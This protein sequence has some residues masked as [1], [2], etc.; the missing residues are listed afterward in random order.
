MRIDNNT[1]SQ[2][3]I[4][5]VAMNMLSE[6]AELS[7]DYLGNTVVQKLFEYC[8]ESVKEAMLE[9][10]AP[11]MAEIGI[12]KNG[13]WAA[14]KIIDVARTPTL[15]KMIV[16]SLRPYAMALFLD[17]FGNYVMQGCLRYQFP[18]N[19]FIFEV[20]L[21]RLWELAQGRFGA[22]A[23][24]ACL[25]SHHATKDQ[26]RMIAAAIALHS[27]QLATNANGALLL[28][29]FLDT[30]TF[31]RRR[32]VLAPRLV[33]HLVHLCTH[34]VAYLTVLKII[35]QRNEPEARDTILQALFFSPNDHVLE[36]ILS[37]H[38]SGTTLIF[39]VLTTP[40]FDEK[41]RPDVVQNVRNVLL[42]IKAQPQH[43][44]KRLM[45]EVGLSTRN[46]GPGARD[47][48][49]IRDDGGRPGSKHSGVNGHVSQPAL[50]N[51]QYYGGVPQQ[52]FDPNIGL[53]RTGSMDS[54]GFEQYQGGVNSLNSPVYAPSPTLTMPT[55]SPQHIQYQQAML[56]NAARNGSIYSP[57][58]VNMNGFQN[59]ASS[60][61]A[62]RNVGTSPTSAPGLAPQFLPQ[63]GFAQPGFSPIMTPQMYQYPIGMQYV[64]QQPQHVGVGRRGRR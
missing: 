10:I 35:N 62:F 39:K 50:D 15:M 4:E 44:Y 2:A 13:T 18:L 25:E 23:M 21:S 7:S 61:D 59:P 29:W 48:H 45:D 16:D 33:P 34:K 9:Q 6:I 22:R 12:H 24:R 31:P 20:M 55:I 38:S 36:Q 49:N 54:N 11:H 37:D 51:R 8:S 46:G 27:V 3:E 63:S 56:A 60:I 26:Q 40:F 53:Q 1:C 14:Q 17:Q 30:C 64:A 28:T 58:N 5:D 43:G 52:A 42:R 47:L 19:N 57:L 32:T 41:I